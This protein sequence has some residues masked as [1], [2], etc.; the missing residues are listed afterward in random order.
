MNSLKPDYSLILCAAEIRREFPTMGFNGPGYYK[1]REDFA[2]VIPIDRDLASIWKQKF[3]PDE[4]F[5]VSVYN[6]RD[7]SELCYYVTLAPLK[8][9]L[10]KV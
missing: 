3:S 2:L 1:H 6:L 10:T 9:E 8:G 5:E 7:I 4:R